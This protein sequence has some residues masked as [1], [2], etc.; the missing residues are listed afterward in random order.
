MADVRSLLKNERAA[1]RINHPDLSYTKSGSPQCTVCDLIIKSETLWD[2]H[3]RSQNHKKNAL[4]A[5]GDAIP[6]ANPSQKRKIDFE[7]GHA[8]KKFK[9]VRGPVDGY[10]ESDKG[11][12]SDVDEASLSSARSPE[13]DDVDVDIQDPDQMFSAGLLNEQPAIHTTAAVDEDEW[14]AF[15]REVAPLAQDQPAGETKPY[16]SATISAEPMTATQVAAQKQADQRPRREVEA[17]D[18]K[19]EEDRRMEEEF[20]IMEAMEER[21]R[22][23]KEKREALRANV[24]SGPKKSDAASTPT[25]HLDLI[26]ATADPTHHSF[27]EGGGGDADDEDGEFYGDWGLQ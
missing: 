25:P 7:E 11:Q 9:S 8:R 14:A 13:E 17:E 26:S 21:V 2:G 5:H 4:N 19:E 6:S 15:E 10:G 3:L 24:S 23:L 27:S 22:R 18:E 20:E 1:R 12:D 16:A